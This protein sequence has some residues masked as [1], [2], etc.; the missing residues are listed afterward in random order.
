MTFELSKNSKTRSLEIQSYLKLALKA[1]QADGTNF[2][3]EYFYNFYDL[4]R[5]AFNVEIEKMKEIDKAIIIKSLNTTG[6]VRNT[7]DSK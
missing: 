1:V 6:E 2:S 7:D 4:N 3:S 5:Q